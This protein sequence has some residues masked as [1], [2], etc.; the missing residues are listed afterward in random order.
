MYMY[1]QEGFWVGLPSAFSL[2]LHGLIMNALY[3]NH[4]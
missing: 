2:P 4:A 3:I 1:T